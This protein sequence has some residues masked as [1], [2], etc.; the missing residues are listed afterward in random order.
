MKSRIGEALSI[1]SGNRSEQGFCGGLFAISYEISLKA[2]QRKNLILESISLR[3]VVLLKTE[4]VSPIIYR[5]KIKIVENV[6]D[7]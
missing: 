2:V 7:V 5:G 1:S 3:E 6:K 4:T